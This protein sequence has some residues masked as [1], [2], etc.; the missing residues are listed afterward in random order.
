MLSRGDGR[1]EQNL[2]SMENGQFTLAR[3]VPP[4]VSRRHFVWLQ[5]TRRN[6]CAIN[7]GWSDIRKDGWNPRQSFVSVRLLCSVNA[8][9]VSLIS[10]VVCAEPIRHGA[11]LRDVTQRSLASLPELTHF[12]ALLLVSRERSFTLVEYSS[13]VTKLT[14]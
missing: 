2:G 6:L 10:A 13:D 8:Q 5:S 12:W 11:C 3:D 7:G 14:P 1:R 9:P 4:N